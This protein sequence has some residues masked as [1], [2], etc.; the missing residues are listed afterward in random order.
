MD[1]SS[2]PAW[3]PPRVRSAPSVNSGNDVHNLCCQC[4]LWDLGGV[5]WGRGVVLEWR[6][7]S[8]HERDDSVSYMFSSL[9][10]PLLCF[11]APTV[12]LFF[13][14]SFIMHLIYLFV[15]LSALC[16]CFSDVAEGE[17]DPCVFV[18]FFFFFC[19]QQRCR[20]NLQSVF[21]LLFLMCDDALG[22]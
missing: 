8:V 7:R 4:T 17:R 6:S 18:C 5:I 11:P 3:V 1:K 15:L 12:C 19:H 21:L 9:G 13:L 16:L 22:L 20:S 14:K 2:N 10:I